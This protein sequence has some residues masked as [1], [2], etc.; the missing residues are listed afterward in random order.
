MPERRKGT[1]H[2]HIPELREKLRRGEI[3]RRDFLR[4]ATLLGMSTAAAYAMA[5]LRPGNGVIPAAHAQTPKKGGNLRV[6]MN[7]KE[8]TD[9]ATYDWSEKGNLAR[10]MTEPLVRINK[11]NIAEPYLA[12]KWEAS[13]DLKTWTF[14]LRKG[15]KWSNGD[16]FGADDVVFNFTRWLDPAVAQL[17]GDA[18]RDALCSSKRRPFHR[19]R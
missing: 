12:E 19:R 2:P 11:D 4:T 18:G 8:M 3:N 6:S 1:R 13:E 7:V 5:G 17:H 15:V 14:H 10:H 9:P 16:D